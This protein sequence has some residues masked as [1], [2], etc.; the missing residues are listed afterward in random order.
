MTRDEF[1]AFLTDYQQLV[2]KH[3]MYLDGCGCCDSPFVNTVDDDKELKSHILHIIQVAA[4]DFRSKDRAAAARERE[5]ENRSKTLGEKLEV[6]KQ[7]RKELD[8]YGR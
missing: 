2:K 1:R 8:R 4:L 6:V 5:A 7:M 3:R